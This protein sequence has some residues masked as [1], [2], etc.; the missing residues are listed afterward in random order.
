ML[1]VQALHPEPAVVSVK[2][3]I[4]VQALIPVPALIPALLLL[5]AL[6]LA[7]LCGGHALTAQDGPTGREYAGLPALNFDADEGFGYGVLLELYDYGPGGLEPYLYTLQPTIF[8]TTGGRRDYTLF[9]DSPHLLPAGWRIDAYLA[10]E[11]Q[12]ASPFY[13][14]GNQSVYHEALEDDDPYFYRFGR[15]RVQLRVNTQRQLGWWGLRALGGFGV[16]HVSIDPVP[17]DSGSTLVES[18]VEGGAVPSGYW[19]Y[20]RAGVVRDTRDR[21]VGPRSGSWS[22]LLVQRVDEALGSEADYTRY[23]ATDRRYLSLAGGLVLA[24]RVMVQ[25]V[26]GDAPFYE[27]FTVE[28]SFKQQ[29]GLGGAKTLRGVPKNRYVGKGLFLWNAELRWRA[30]EWRLVGKPFHLV[31]NGFVDSGRVW[32]EETIPV[33]E[34]LKDLHHG[35]G[36]GARVGMGD[37][38]VV[39]VDGG[40]SAGSGLGLYIGLGYLF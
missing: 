8:R 13:G 32:T 24:S 1:P 33:A 37:N 31:L 5:A 10:S 15:T 38:F 39:A 30:A 4:P 34:V 26:A 22:E 17:Y 16:T 18:I 19:N 12:I 21:E 35:Y 25:Q 2:A 23:T 14:M 20:V 9:F 11:E 6:L 40:T 7:P 3:L 29:E 27:L 28:S 36:G